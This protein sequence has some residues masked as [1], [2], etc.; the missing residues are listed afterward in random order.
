MGRGREERRHGVRRAGGSRLLSQTTL[1]QAGSAPNPRPASYCRLGTNSSHSD[2][3]D[4]NKRN[5][6][7]A[8]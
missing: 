5:T 4:T 7:E 6:E 2:I 8:V 3:G 1:I